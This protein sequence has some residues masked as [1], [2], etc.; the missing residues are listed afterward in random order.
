MAGHTTGLPRHRPVHPAPLV[1]G[2]N[3]FENSAICLS[4]GSLEITNFLPEQRIQ[5]ST[6]GCRIRLCLCPLDDTRMASK[7][8]AKIAHL[9][10]LQWE[11]FFTCWRYNIDFFRRERSVQWNFDAGVPFYS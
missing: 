7:E 9:T 3:F 11:F 8:S 6:K 4:W 5:M 10:D 2:G 1:L